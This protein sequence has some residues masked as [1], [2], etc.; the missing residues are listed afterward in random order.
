M[1]NDTT[2]M[3]LDQ[4]LISEGLVTQEQVAEAL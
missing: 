3:R 4:I 2:T 1:K